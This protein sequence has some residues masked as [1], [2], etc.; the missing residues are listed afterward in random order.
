MRALV[1][2]P[3]IILCACP[4]APE[5]E[6]PGVPPEVRL[7]GV[8]LEY[9]QGDRRV[10]IGRATRLTY[11]R[12]R[13][14]FEAEEVTLRFPARTVGMSEVRAPKVRGNLDARQADGMGG[15]TMTTPSGLTGRTERAHFDGVREIASG[16]DPI[17]LEAPG[18]AL[19]ANRFVFDFPSERFAFDGGVTSRVGGRR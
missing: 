14:D 10:T 5:A 4:R 15:V 3:W 18:H 13:S 19:H 6:D 8:T 1:L 12:T 11:E 7:R 9:F 17:A 16:T 2:A